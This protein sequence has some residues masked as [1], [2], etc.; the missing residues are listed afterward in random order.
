LV[1][2]PEEENGLNGVVQEDVNEQEEESVEM[3]EKV[4]NE[5]EQKV[6]L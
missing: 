6:Q 4:A 2:L 1:R 5:E 3:T